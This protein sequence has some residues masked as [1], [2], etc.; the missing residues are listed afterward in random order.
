[1]RDR[2]TGGGPPK[3]RDEVG[4]ATLALVLVIPA[5]VLLVSTVAQFVVYYHASHLATAAAQEAA[6][7]AQLAD[8]T[9]AAARA[10]GEDFI[11]QAG[12]NLVLEPQVRVRRDV[13]AQVARVE[14]RGR[15]PQLVPAMSWTITARAAGPLE[16][17][18]A[19]S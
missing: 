8:G 7:S 4:V 17:F 3:R 11:A 6:R 15:A 19:A 2:R 18:E 9:E 13:A 10:R 16:R 5:V 12:P 14:V 1:V